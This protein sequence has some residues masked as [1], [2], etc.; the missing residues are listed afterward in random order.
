V[1]RKAVIL[2]AGYGTR[3][4]DLTR[5]TPKPMLPVFGKPMLEWQILFLRAA[6]VREIGINLHYLG[7]QIV[8]YFEDG[9]K[10]NVKIH[11][12]MES[13]IMG[14]GGAYIGLKDFLNEPFIA[15]NSDTFVFCKLDNFVRQFE[16]SGMVASMALYTLP[17]RKN[18]TPVF[19]LNDSIRQIGGPACEECS[20][21]VF[22]GLQILTPVIFEYLPNNPS[23]II[24][25]F[26]QPAIRKGEKIGAFT[27][28]D[29]WI[30]IGTK[31][32]YLHF[33]GN[34]DNQK[35]ITKIGEE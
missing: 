16:H 11:Y 18:Y 30:D 34:K 1:I 9:E 32:E 17:T 15:L 26:Y 14:T 8:N 12:S 10:W 33:T 7:N 22:T 4:K 13:R 27:K 23:S 25:H 35:W 2:A 20:K 19:F 6:G 3:M 29:R 31:E 5:H 24:H 21:G 28:I